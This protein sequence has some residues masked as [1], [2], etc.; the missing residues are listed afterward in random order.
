MKNETILQQVVIW[1]L[2][3]VLLIFLDIGRVGERGRKEERGER[4][5]Y[6]RTEAETEAEVEKLRQQTV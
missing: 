2:T 3:A 6:I 4:S 1:K 5:L